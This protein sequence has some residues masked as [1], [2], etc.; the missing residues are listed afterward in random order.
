MYGLIE[1]C[2]D[3]MNYN[4]YFDELYKTSQKLEDYLLSLFTINYNSICWDWD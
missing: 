4:Q 3:G 2:Y 1:S